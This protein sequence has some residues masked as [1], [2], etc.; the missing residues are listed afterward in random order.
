M[1]TN[2]RVAYF[3]GQI[4]PE[5]QACISIRDT[6]FTYGNGVFDA[7]RT[8][9]GQIFKLTEH[10]NRLFHSLKYVDLDIGLSPDE[11][12]QLTLEVTEQNLPLR[13]SQQLAEFL[14][15][16]GF[17]HPARQIQKLRILKLW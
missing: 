15:V 6:G 3:N 14:L 17:E 5:S 10:V 8:F 16:P 12:I 7:A 2:E 11:V 4:I 9:N 13:G 1:T